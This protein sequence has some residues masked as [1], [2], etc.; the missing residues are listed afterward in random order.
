[1]GNNEPVRLLWSFETF[2][3]GMNLSGLSQG[4]RLW[5]ACQGGSILVA[6]KDGE[7]SLPL[8]EDLRSIGLATDNSHV[9]GTVE[10]VV[11]MAAGIPMETPAPGG[12]R[13]EGLRSLFDGISYSFFAVAARALEVVDWDLSHRFCGKCGTATTLRTGERARECPASATLA[14]PLPSSWPS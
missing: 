4:P 12:F 6:V 10:G 13:F 7:L 1:V 11:C 2:V 14:S 8:T 3:P 5:F 9:L